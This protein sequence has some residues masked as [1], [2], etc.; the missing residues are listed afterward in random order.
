VPISGALHQGPNFKVATVA[1][2]WHLV[3]D[4]IG[5]GFEPHTSLQMGHLVRRLSMMTLWT[6]LKQ[7]HSASDDTKLVQ[8][9]KIKP[10]C[11]L[12]LYGSSMHSANLAGA[13]RHTLAHSS[14]S[15]WTI[16]VRMYDS[17]LKYKN[18]RF[19]INKFTNEENCTRA[20]PVRQ[21]NIKI[22]KLANK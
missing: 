14:H 2:R 4:L 7:Q 17:S 9:K 20:Q 16:T 5:S 11:A 18:I 10:P 22:I 13:E 8:T 19:E 6:G 12:Y 15:T 21:L 1:S 3:G